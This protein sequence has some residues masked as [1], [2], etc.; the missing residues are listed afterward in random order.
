M[1]PGALIVQCRVGDDDIELAM[2]QDA[3]VGFTSWIEATPP[4]QPGMLT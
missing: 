3:Y 1:L 4:D 2:S